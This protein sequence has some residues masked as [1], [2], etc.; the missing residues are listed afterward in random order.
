MVW[1]YPKI[2]E[3]LRAPVTLTFNPTMVWFYHFGV[4]SSQFTSLPGF[5]SHY[6][7]ILS[8]Y[9]C[10]ECWKVIWLSIPLWSDFISTRRR[11][12]TRKTKNAFNPTMVWFY[13]VA[14][15]GELPRP[16]GLSIP[17]WSDFISEKA[18]FIVYY[19]EDIFQ[20][21]YGLILSDL[22][23]GY[24]SQRVPF[25]PTMVWFYL[26]RYKR[27]HH[28]EH[29]RKLSI[30]LWSDFIMLPRVRTAFYSV[31]SIPLWSDFILCKIWAENR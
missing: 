14:T 31:L 26:E 7:L 10:Y 22:L 27:Q 12:I 28:K 15:R 19:T 17:L 11:D 1:F 30:P 20:S 29:Q 25:N 24:C 16:D 8:L 9:F 2:I 4:D 13:L 5:Q 23:R 21:H 3:E 18:L 6:G